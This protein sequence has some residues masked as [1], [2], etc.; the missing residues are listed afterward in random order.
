VERSLYP[1]RRLG[2]LAFLF[3]LW[4]LVTFR[5]SHTWRTGGAMLSFICFIAILLTAASFI[6]GA[7]SL[8]LSPHGF[9]IRNWFKEE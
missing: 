8:K 3:L 7:M 1:T 9:T 6:P 5:S 4:V 2:R